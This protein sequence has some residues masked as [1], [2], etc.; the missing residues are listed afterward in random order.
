M[1]RLKYEKK[2]REEVLGFRFEVKKIQSRLE[3]RTK[4]GVWKGTGKEDIV[5]SRVDT[6]I[7]LQQVIKLIWA[8]LEA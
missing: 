3:G 6:G 1:I 7:S 5:E 8:V 4:R 2:C